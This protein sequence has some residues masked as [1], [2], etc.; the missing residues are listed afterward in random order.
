VRT[1]YGQ[2]GGESIFHDF[3][4]TSFMDGPYGRPIQYSLLIISTR[5][6]YKVMQMKDCNINNASVYFTCQ[7]AH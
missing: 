6:V 7:H 4:R 2:G 5:L 1:F 3:V